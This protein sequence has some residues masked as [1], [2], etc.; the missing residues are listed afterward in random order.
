MKRISKTIIGAFLMIGLVV[1]SCKKLDTY[2]ITSYG[3]NNFWKHPSHAD[4]ALNGAYTLLQGALNTEFIYYGE[5]RADLISLNLEN[6]VQ[7]I[8]VANNRLDV[9]MAF[10]DW[11]N[12]YKVVQQVNLIIKHMPVMLKD[13]V[14]QESNT[15][16]YNNYKRILGQ[17]YGLRALCYFYM[18][19][20]WGEVPLVT[21][22]V[23]VVENI[24]DFKTPRTPMLEIHNQIILDLQTARNLLNSYEDYNSKLTRSQIT[25]GAIDALFTDFYLWIGD[26]GKAIASADNL[27][28]DT[29]EPKNASVYGYATLAGTTA[30]ERYT[31]DYAKMFT[32]GYSKESIFEIAFNMDENSTSSIYGIYGESSLSQFKASNIIVNKISSSDL[33]RD[34]VFNTGTT[35]SYVYKFFEK[36]GFDRTTMNDKNVIIYRLADICLLKA[37]ALMKRA[38]SGDRDKALILLN[39]IKLRAG[40]VAIPAGDFALM[41]NTEV[42]DEILWERARELCFEGKRWFD[43]VRNNKV[44]ELMPDKYSDPRNFV[45]PINLKI[46]RQNPNIIQN[47]Y[48]K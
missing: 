32:E 39:K 20:V 41:S 18:I 28:T 17:A 6:N 16:S 40:L 26:A 48:Y 43:L 2:P 44:I 7:S 37:E 4:G 19:R 5:A 42:I 15:S 10:A 34:I 24:N 35:K 33:R 25:R 1:S 11:G 29:G 30:A 27:V 31:S 14:F 21:E 12:L 8:N 38:N 36:S 9:N 13:N 45:W 23:E 22:P 46:I 47:E 3:N